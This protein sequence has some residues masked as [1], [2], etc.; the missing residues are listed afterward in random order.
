[1]MSA[2]RIVVPSAIPTIPA[3][4]ISLVATHAK[5]S[6]STVPIAA[7]TFDSGADAALSA[8]PS[9]SLPT[10][11]AMSSM[12]SG[13]GLKINSTRVTPLAPHQLIH[14]D[15]RHRTLDAISYRHS[16]QLSNSSNSQIGLESSTLLNANSGNLAENRGDAVIH[17]H[18]EGEA[19]G[20]AKTNVVK[21]PGDQHQATLEAVMPL[22]LSIEAFDIVRRHVLVGFLPGAAGSDPS[23]A[24]AA[25]GGGL[26][27]A[28]WQWES[29]LLWVDYH[30]IV[31]EWAVLRILHKSYESW[32][33]MI[34]VRVALS[35]YLAT[36]RPVES[37]SSEVLVS[38]IH[39]ML[40][41]QR[42]LLANSLG[43]FFDDEGTAI[44]HLPR[45]PDLHPGTADPH[46]LGRLLFNLAVDGDLEQVTPKA[47]SDAKEGKEKE[48]N[49]GEHGTYSSS[50]S[51]S[52]DLL[53]NLVRLVAEHV[54]NGQV[55]FNDHQY[56]QHIVSAAIR[57][58]P[59]G[60]LGYPKILLTDGTI[61]RVASTHDLY[62]IFERC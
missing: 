30:R 27:G 16:T 47:T 56:L 35:Q 5:V 13:D 23:A 10:S 3:K 31:M 54:I 19:M 38:E 53:L 9:A 39:R 41:D 14:V 22:I 18:G 57:K 24:A 28:F 61:R 33:V 11:S 7:A 6:P 26:L 55:N 20:K 25:A 37:S 4:R 2:R 58:I 51:S 15:H 50:S 62:R 43:I 48:A 49:N 1:M 21:F 29:Y 60:C 52:S 45:L 46:E 59:L 8:I 32:P 36:S 34:N 17:T 44:T 42:A 40:L 12:A